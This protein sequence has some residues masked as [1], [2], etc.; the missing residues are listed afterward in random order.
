MIEK[1]DFI[2]VE[3][4]ATAKE[5][6]Q[7]LET[8][9]AEVAKKY[10]IY[11]PEYKYGPK[12]VC[13]GQGQLL[14]SIEEEIKD[15][16]FNKEIEITLP[17]KKAFGKKDPKLLQLIS[18]SQFRKQKINP[19]PGLPVHI[20]NLMGI[21]RTISPGRVIVDFNHPLAGKH[22]LYKIK[23][24]MKVEDLKEKVDSIISRY[25][26][27]FSSELKDSELLVKTEYDLNEKL[28]EDAV[29]RTIE[30]L[31]IIKKVNFVKE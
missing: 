17:P 9:D 13:I 12:V 5:T 30:L 19:Y 18:M 21:V 16:E 27:E 10:S 22:I 3:L 2:K 23:I 26:F 14:P 24:L 7:I 15:K 31:P 6:D 20:D 8:T 25:N 29:K 11:S 28:K 4:T 1:N